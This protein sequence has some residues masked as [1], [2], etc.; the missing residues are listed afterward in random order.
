MALYA[1]LGKLCS[2]G[3]SREVMKERIKTNQQD[4]DRL[5]ATGYGGP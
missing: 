2:E 4:A 5:R 3:R 1:V